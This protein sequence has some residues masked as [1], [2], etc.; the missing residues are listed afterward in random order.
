MSWTCSLCGIKLVSKHR[1][2]AHEIN[3]RKNP[4]DPTR[5]DA[6]QKK[7]EK[8]F[9][10]LVLQSPT[11]CPDSP[12]VHFA[13]DDV[14]LEIHLPASPDDVPLEIH[15]PASP[16]PGDEREPP[17]V[18]I[19]NL[20]TRGSSD[21]FIKFPCR[22]LQQIVGVLPNVRDLVP[23]QNKWD[24]YV[25]D[26]FNI[27]TKQFW[28]MF[29]PIHDQSGTTID[30]VLRCTKTAFSSSWDQNGWDH[31]PTTRRALFAKISKVEDF[32]PSVIH[33]CVVDLSKFASVPV[34]KQRLIFH[35]LD[36]VWA[37][38]MAAR[39]QPAH[40]MHWIPHYLRHRD[41][42]HE[43]YYGLGI[44]FGTSFARAFKDCPEGTFPMCMS[45]H[46]DGTNAHGLYSTPI[47]IGVCNTNS[48][49]PSAHYCIGYMPVLTDVGGSEAGDSTDIK[50]EIRQQCV[51]A[52]L[53]VMETAAQL[54]VRCRLPSVTPGC[55][56]VMT[57]IPRLVSMNLDQ[58]E[59]QLYFGMLN[60][61]YVI[62]VVFNHLI[63][64]CPTSYTSF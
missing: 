61:T 15:L 10:P 55:E 45:L 54:G 19:Q 4:D 64:C 50:F 14:P 51:C 30:T 25:R 13:P 7:N 5:C 42:A 39:E 62:H 49:S 44:Q 28:Q 3:Y 46:W 32:W 11:Q 17:P 38:V 36:P 31:F 6:I 2:G 43:P 37:W 12:T 57:L 53:R 20:A 41:Y 63:L 59:A 40:E 8:Y 27:C 24:K 22:G 21:V 16:S 58:P 9:A 56:S 18:N 1:I 47:C 35:F 52:I 29:L 33:T 34:N 23:L 48:A 26:V 60:R